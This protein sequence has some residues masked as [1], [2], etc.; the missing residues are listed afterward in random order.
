MNLIRT[1]PTSYGLV[2]LGSYYDPN[3]AF[4]GE[5]LPSNLIIY[6]IYLSGQRIYEIVRPTVRLL[7]ADVVSFLS[8]FYYSRS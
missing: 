4:P 2:K 7:H 6:F 5:I 8:I 3:I 1:R